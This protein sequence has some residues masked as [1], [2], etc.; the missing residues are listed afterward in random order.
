[1]D[2]LIIHSTF[3]SAT[4]MLNELHWPTY[5]NLLLDYQPSIK[6]YTTH[7]CNPSFIISFQLPN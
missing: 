2:H 7:Q 6:L 4:A 1:M 5:K 3:D